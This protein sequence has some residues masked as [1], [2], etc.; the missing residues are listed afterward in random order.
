MPI[1]S[2]YPREPRHLPPQP[3]RTGPQYS[4]RTPPPDTTGAEVHYI[5]KQI[6][7]RTPMV[8]KLVGGELVRGVIEYYDRDMI[9][10]TRGDGPHL[11]IRKENVMYMYKDDQPR[12][13]NAP[14][15][16]SPSFAPAGGNAFPHRRGNS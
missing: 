12:R 4:A 2:G 13:G 7:A 15:H 16:E 3:R 8:F 1:D 5:I 9:K 14:R 11:L 10:L 6:E